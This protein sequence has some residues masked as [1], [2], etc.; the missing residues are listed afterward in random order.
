L[1]GF[2]HEGD[3][4]A[5][6]S[7][8]AGSLWLIIVVSIA[9]MWN[10][11]RWAVSVPEIAV[12]M[13]AALLLLACALG[14][15]R[16]VLSPVMLPLAAV[17]LWG[18]LQIWTGDSVYAWRTQVAVLYWAANF[19]VFFVALQVSVDAGIRRRFL[20]ALLLFGFVIA[21]VSPIQSLSPSNKV[22]WIFTPD[23]N[24]IPQMGPFPYKNQY[25]AFIELLL[26]Y[27]LFRVLT[28]EK[29]VLYYALVV[30]VLYTSVIAASSRMGFFLATAEM[31][32]VPALV[33]SRQRIPWRRLR[34]SGFL[35]LAIL[36]MLAAAAGPNILVEKFGTSDPYAGRREYTEASLAMI[37]D[38]P[39][40]GFG[41]GT[42]STVYPKYAKSDDGLFINQAHDDWAQWAV[43]GGLP[44]VAIMLA[45]ALWA[46]PRA[47]RTVWGIGVVAIFVHCL[48]DY[49]IQRAG[50]ALVMFSMLAAVASAGA[51]K[52]ADAAEHRTPL[53]GGANGR[54]RALEGH[55]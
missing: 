19:A 42:W 21:F 18:L 20:E 26:P 54:Q 14:W 12:F 5:M 46:I 44:F 36:L 41:L 29:R 17:A 4:A 38:R 13:V 34:E 25:A 8:A 50:V 35:F 49:P 15:Q 48:V 33:M 32:V 40:F 7:L 28:S 23:P 30:A 9:A 22:F 43:E 27:A 1:R 39:M 53:R 3:A 31:V 6:K 11:S 45:I 37:K 52:G 55:P 24:L 51:T 2:S 10:T 47:V 16:L